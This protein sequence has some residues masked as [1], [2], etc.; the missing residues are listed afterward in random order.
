VATRLQMMHGVV[1]LAASN[2]AVVVRGGNVVNLISCSREIQ[3]T[4]ASQTT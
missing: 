1:F 4:H 2:V 3:D